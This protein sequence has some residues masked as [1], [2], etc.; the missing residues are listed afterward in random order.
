MAGYYVEMG[1][2]ST[3][4]DLELE[5]RETLAAAEQYEGI[6]LFDPERGFRPNP[7]GQ[8]KFFEQFG[9]V[10]DKPPNP[11]PPY[12]WESLVGGI[13]SGKSRCGAVWTI[14]QAEWYPEQR[15]AVLANSYPQLTTSTLVA[16]VEA[17]REYNVPLEPYVESVEENAI[18]IANM[19]RCHL[20]SKSAFVRVLSM[21]SFTGKTQT[22]RGQELQWAWV[23]EGAYSSEQ[24]FQTLDGRLRSKHDVF[25]R[26]LITTSP[27][28]FNWL[29][30]R[31]GAI[32][33]DERLKRLYHLISIPTHENIAYLGEDY[34]ESLTANYTDELAQQELLGMFI[35]TKVGLIYKYFNRDIHV[36]KGQDADV[37]AYDP[38]DPLHI[39]FDFNAAPAVAVLCQVRSGE[40]HIFREFFSMDSDL[41]EICGDIRDWIVEQKPRDSNLYV[42]G[43]ASG[44]QHVPHTRLTA[45]DIVFSTLKETGLKLTRRFPDANPPVDNR[46]NSVNNGFRH[47]K[48]YLSEDCAQLIRDFEECCWDAGSIDKSDQLR[49][50]LSD[51]FGYLVEWTMPFKRPQIVKMSQQRIAGVM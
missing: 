33:R 40:I 6:L 10:V 13:G 47:L 39:A 50:H 31:F 5:T 41:W 44:R 7:G 36:L 27:A 51:A 49:T 15:G 22:A 26:G 28:G 34:V 48:I 29:Y 16:L 18:K 8:Q 42:Y 25:C 3:A 37:L 43:D 35:N 24:S 12:R 14:L 11:Y 32:D 4:L 23:D 38:R 30:H 21:A 19:R 17:C 9:G 20:G 45:W 46:I 1:F 2:W